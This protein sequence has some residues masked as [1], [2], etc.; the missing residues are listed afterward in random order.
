MY[1]KEMVQDVSL[2]YLL[3]YWST[4]MHRVLAESMRKRH[5]AYLPRTRYRRR[6]IAA[7]W[8][9]AWPR[10]PIHDA[11]AARGRRRPPPAVPASP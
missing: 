11:R 7:R 6:V 1:L 2:L 3:F 4:S 5:T 8:V 9:E 10:G